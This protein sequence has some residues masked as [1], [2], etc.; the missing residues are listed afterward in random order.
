MLVGSRFIIDRIR[1]WTSR[2][3]VLAP[4]CLRLSHFASRHS[5]PPIAV[6][7]SSSLASTSYNVGTRKSSGSNRCMHW[8]RLPFYLGFGLGSFDRFIDLPPN[9]RFLHL[10]QERGLYSL[11]GQSLCLSLDCLFAR[12]GLNCSRP[13]LQSFIRGFSPT[14]RVSWQPCCYDFS[15]SLRKD[16]QLNKLSVGVRVSLITS[17]QYRYQGTLAAINSIEGTLT[18]QTVRFWGSENRLPSCGERKGPAIGSVFD[19]ITFWVSNVIHLHIYDEGTDSNG[20]GDQAVVKAKVASAAPTT[21]A[22]GDS[23]GR[24]QRSRNRKQKNFWS[25]KDQ[26]RAGSPL[27]ES[28]QTKERQRMPT[29]QSNTTGRISRPGSSRSVGRTLVSYPRRGGGRFP[30][31][32]TYVAMPATSFISP[33]GLRRRGIRGPR[34]SQ[35]PGTSATN[36]GLLSSQPS[37]A[38]SGFYR[39]QGP[40]NGGPPVNG[41]N[42]ST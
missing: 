29:G 25:K 9:Y 23:V 33:T 34:G 28:N 20:L 22:S 18:L 6:S 16:L 12:P 3:L 27:E 19:S 24:R 7:L 15:M 2:M 35:V 4:D 13:T 1:F 41:A 30:G 37:Q 26:P 38:V 11:S 10:S 17:A 42:F 40:H 36:Q 32:P 5:V 39:F 21:Q 31:P 14:V 8:S